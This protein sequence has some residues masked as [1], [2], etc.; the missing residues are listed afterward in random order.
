[1]IDSV[2]ELTFYT[3]NM[4]RMGNR[5]DPK[6]NRHPAINVAAYWMRHGIDAIRLGGRAK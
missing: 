3:V 1:M 4:W 6:P 2:T 5:K